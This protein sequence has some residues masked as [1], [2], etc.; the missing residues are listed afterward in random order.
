MR[1]DWRVLTAVVIVAIAAGWF[2]TR[3]VQ[4]PTA[5]ELETERDLSEL[6][7]ALREDQNTEFE[8]ART[9]STSMQRFPTSLQYRRAVDFWRP[10]FDKGGKEER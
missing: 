5:D 9:E 10:V 6:S 3:S 4:Q 8:V 2:L 7:E 1:Y